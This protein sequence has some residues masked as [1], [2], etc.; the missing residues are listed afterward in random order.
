MHNIK[1]RPIKIRR[2]LGSSIVLCL[3]LFFISNKLMI[4]FI[5]N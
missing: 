1:K 2:C 3:H 5:L 4:K